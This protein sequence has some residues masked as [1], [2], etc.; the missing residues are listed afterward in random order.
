MK[1]DTIIISIHPNHVEKIWSGEKLFEFRK[2][3]PNHIKYMLVYSTSPIKKITTI[4]EI[5]SILSE[6]VAEIWNTTQEKAGISKDFYMNY[7]KDHTIAYAIK[8]KNVYKFKNPILLNSIDDIHCVPQSYIYLKG[9]LEQIVNKMTK[10]EQLNFKN[11]INA[12]KT[13][14]SIKNKP[15]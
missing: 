5:E 14:N 8:I 15:V 9:S 7:F 13:F 2:R 11:F 10:K 12:S 6:S 4:I 3:I 1:S